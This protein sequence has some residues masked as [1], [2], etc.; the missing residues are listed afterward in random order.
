LK[1]EIKYIIIFLVIILSQLGFYG[2]AD[3]QTGYS[4]K[5]TVKKCI[6]F[7]KKA[8]NIL[9]NFVKENDFLDKERA[10]SYYVKIANYY[11]ET[12][13]NLASLNYLF[14]YLLDV[15]KDIKEFSP[16]IYLLIIKNFIEINDLNNAQYYLNGLNKISLKKE[17]LKMDYFFI[18]SEYYSKKNKPDSSKLYY[19]KFKTFKNN[20]LDDYYLKLGKLLYFQSKFFAAKKALSIYASS[21]GT[22]CLSKYTAS[23][24]ISEIYLKLNMYDSANYELNKLNELNLLSNSSSLKKRYYRLYYKYYLSKVDLS[25]SCIYFD[26]LEN[27]SDSV[28]LNWQT[29]ILLLNQKTK[30]KIYNQNQKLLV[31]TNEQKNKYI[32]VLIIFL[33]LAILGAVY[34]YRLV[35]KNKQLAKKLK[36]VN[37][38]LEI[39]SEDMIKKAFEQERLNTE[40]STIHSAFKHQVEMKEEVFNKLKEKSK[41]VIDS[42]YYARNIQ[43]AIFPVTD[44]LKRD[45]NDFFI[46]WRPKDVVSGDFYW[47]K[48]MEDNYY[49]AVGDCTGHGV[50]GALMSI[51]G[52]SFLN[53]IIA[54]YGSISPSKVLDLLNERILRSINQEGSKSVLRDGMDISLVM[55]PSKGGTGLFSAAYNN[56][57]IIRENERSPELYE[58]K[59]DRRPIGLY[60]QYTKKFT[61]QSFSIK[62][63]DTIYLLTDGYT[64]QFG[65]GKQKKFMKKRWRDFILK[66]NSHPLYIQKLLIKEKF[67]AWKGENEQLDDILVVGIKI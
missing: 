67:L 57:N 62:K 31:Q 26:K 49:I 66:I 22:D 17:E 61:E 7:K 4:Q 28:N 34:M 9:E 36:N 32:L 14:Y 41:S 8:V 58:L 39:F 48:K 18:L 13:E 1:I 43:H 10:L 15:N 44:I 16:E 46:L 21:K 47:F 64:D 25:K 52:V 24:L 56:V 3:S 35:K 53:D 54:K 23:L 40:L 55:I 6:S 60:G 29:D 59:A 63:G 37:G 19:M 33:L 30:I 45:F 5:T 2:K 20:D 50:P 27:M 11:N 65:G 38:E 42:L 51:L 12:G